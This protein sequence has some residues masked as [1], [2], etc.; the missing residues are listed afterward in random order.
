MLPLEKEL[1][2][3]SDH[4]FLVNLHQEI[5]HTLDHRQIFRTETEAR[6]SVLD[7]IHFPTKAAKYWQSLREQAVMLDELMSLSFQFRR[8]EVN[9]KRIN[10][11]IENLTDS[12]DIEEATIDLDECCFKRSTMRDVAKD[13]VREILM[14]SN[15]KCELD[16]GTFDINNVNTHQLV[17]YTTQFIIRASAIDLS[18]LTEGESINLQG[19][20]QTAIRRCKE[21]GVL[22][23]VLLCLPDKICQQLRLT[24]L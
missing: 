19:Q 12:I 10:K 13:R 15:I 11:K 1:L 23:Q 21:V 16:D 20:L 5:N 2:S 4:Q 3:E 18:Q 17:S 7:D 8:N 14:W 22:D 9:I 24:L 6:V